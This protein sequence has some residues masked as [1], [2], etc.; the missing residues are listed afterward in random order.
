MA[1]IAQDFDD[2]A[3]TIAD[4]DERLTKIETFREH[5]RKAAEA[6]AELRKAQS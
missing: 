2:V 3:R 5:Q 1:K 6:S 4:L